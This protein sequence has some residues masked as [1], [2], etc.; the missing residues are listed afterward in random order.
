MSIDQLPRQVTPSGKDYLHL[1]F[2]TVWDK[3]MV[4]GEH[5]WKSMETSDFTHYHN[6][7][8]GTLSLTNAFLID[9]KFFF[10]SKHGLLGR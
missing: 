8:S 4:M 5:P 3:V 2:L 9:R 1:H 7:R 6:C 10:P